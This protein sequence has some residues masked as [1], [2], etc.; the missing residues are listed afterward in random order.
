[1]RNANP[2]TA[3]EIG[4][5]TGLATVLM[6]V[7]APNARIFTVN[8]SPEEIASGEG[9]KLTTIALER[10]KIGIEYRDRGLTNVTQIYA[11]TAKW[12]PDIDRIDVAFIDGSHD[13]DFVVNDTEKVLRH[14]GSG[15]F[16][17][18]HDFNLEL[19]DKYAWIRSVCLGVEKL[20]ERGLLSGRVFHVRDS[21]TGVYRVA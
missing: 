6:A 2:K 21:W 18:W 5:S 15:S 1:M 16:V 12:E 13:T 9:G 10:E 17:L 8:I 11:N 7:N 3:L 14:M 4:T 19:V 20:Y